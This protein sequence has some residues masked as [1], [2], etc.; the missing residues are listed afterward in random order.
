MH[1]EALLARARRRNIV[2]L[3]LQEAIF[4]GAFGVGGLIL[5][6]VVGTQVMDWHWP[7]LL[8]ALVFGI[9]LHRLWKRVPSRYQ[10]AQWIDRHLGLRDFISTA[11][12]FRNRAGTIVEHQRSVAE[13]IAAKTDPRAAL[14]FVMPR[15][16]YATSALMMIALA[17]LGVRYG[18][19]RNL[20]L[21]PPVVEALLDVFRAPNVLM[22]KKAA[23]PQ[24]KLPPELKGT[25]VALEDE[26]KDEA[27]KVDRPEEN[28][29]VP[30]EI[31]DVNDLPSQEVPGGPEGKEMPDEAGEGNEEGERDSGS[32]SRSSDTSEDPAARGASQ[33]GDKSSKDPDS[34]GEQEDEQD[35]DLMEKMKDA[36][37][38][39]LNKF[40]IKPPMTGESRRETASRHKGE[41]RGGSQRMKGEKGAEMPAK[42]QGEGGA[43]ADQKGDQEGQGGE[44]TQS[45]SGKTGDR[46]GDKQNAKEGN[47]GVGKA[48]GDKDV[49]LAAEHLDAMGRIS[50]ILGKRA[51]NLQGEV[52]VEVSAGKQTL[53][54]PYSQSQ[55]GHQQG[56]G[57]IHRDEVPLIYQQY[58]QQYFEEI[59]KTS[60]K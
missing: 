3:I 21:R 43:T 19:R 55:A 13:E 60:Q 40:N 35:S 26:A 28:Y 29:I 45:A 22:A 42:P 7:A 33:K 30:P 52:M 49:K 24:S 51:Q 17:M 10:L 47:S 54:T 15:S 36:F 16:I 37:A 23:A 58:V 57:E 50:E 59:H 41:K 56:T 6:L 1:L 25:S 9:G 8:F 12:H 5:L 48:D 44:K 11:F 46:P 38:N 14:P 4:A 32:D 18:V 39:L 2:H 34:S 31:P 53:K 27:S 20:D